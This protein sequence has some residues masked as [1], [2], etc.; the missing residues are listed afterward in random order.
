MSNGILATVI[1]IFVLPINAP[2]K[3]LQ[4]VGKQAFSALTSIRG[5]GNDTVKRKVFSQPHKASSG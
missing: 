2:D 1:F 4:W 5:H 3:L